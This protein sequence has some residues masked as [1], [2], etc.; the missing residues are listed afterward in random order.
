MGVLEHVAGPLGSFSS[1][2]STPVLALAGFVSF[3]VLAVVLNVLSQVLLKNPNH[4]PMVFHW[5]P[6][7]GSTVT[8]GMDPYKFFFANKEKVR[9]VNSRRGKTFCANKNVA[10][11]CLHLHSARQ[12]DDRVLGYQGQQLHSERQGQGRQR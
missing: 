7:V 11:R 9:G 10:R 5:F 12:E 2:A 1:N 4:P 6:W 8:Y 3:V